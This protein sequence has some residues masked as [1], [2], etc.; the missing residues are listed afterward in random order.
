MFEIINNNA[1]LN[2]SKKKS[3]GLFF[4]LTFIIK[5][6]LCASPDNFILYEKLK[7]ASIN[8]ET[9]VDQNNEVDQTSKRFYD[10][11]ISYQ[12]NDK[13]YNKNLKNNMKKVE[14]TNDVG[15]ASRASPSKKILHTLAI[16]RIYD[17]NFEKI[18]YHYHSMIRKMQNNRNINKP[19]HFLL[20]YQASKNIILKSNY[21]E[22]TFNNDSLLEIYK[23]L[24]KKLLKNYYFDFE[25]SKFVIEIREINLFFYAKQDSH[26]QNQNS[27]FKDYESKIF[28]FFDPND[29][30]DNFNEFLNRFSKYLSLNLPSRHQSQLDFVFFSDNLNLK[31]FAEGLIKP[32]FS[33]K[34]KYR[35]QNMLV[36][37]EKITHYHNCDFVFIK[38]GHISYVFI[39]KNLNEEEKNS[40]SI[41][42]IIAFCNLVKKTGQDLY[43]IQKNTSDFR[44]LNFNRVYDKLD[45]S[46][47]KQILFLNTYENLIKNFTCAEDTKSNIEAY[48]FVD[49]EAEE[50]IKYY[51]FSF[52]QDINIFYLKQCLFLISKKYSIDA[53]GNLLRLD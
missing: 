43:K 25:N 48:V 2:M 27:D 3:K 24:N 17:L 40:D 14:L 1:K 39:E 31:L 9:L 47:P 26:A 28:L 16:V 37:K 11:S 38:N 22:I 23:T 50:T 41:I 10:S 19:T 21:K 34:N 53:Q 42:D 35:N 36:S 6:S 49:H 18:Q 13:D 7:E 5:T 20:F 46:E 15:L 33:D 52:N 12:E 8:I 45:L 29:I 44:D 51:Y 32:N 4:I 30:K